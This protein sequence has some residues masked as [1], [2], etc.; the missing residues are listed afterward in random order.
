[1]KKGIIASILTLLIFSTIALAQPP[2]PHPH[3][4]SIHGAYRHPYY[5][6]ISR[7]PRHI[8]HPHYLIRYSYPMYPPPPIARYP[9]YCTYRNGILVRSYNYPYA[10]YS[11]CP[12]VEFSISL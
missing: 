4:G 5:H 10:M 2:R 8:H 1:M 3:H 7:P 6:N 11:N 9:R 12:A